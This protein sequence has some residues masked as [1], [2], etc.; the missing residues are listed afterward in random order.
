MFCFQEGE[1]DEPNFM[2]FEE[3]PQDGVLNLPKVSDAHSNQKL[4]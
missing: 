3:L 1:N 2:D 4:F